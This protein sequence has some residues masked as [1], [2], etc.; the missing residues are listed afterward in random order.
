MTH[1]S[2]P[3]RSEEKLRFGKEERSVRVEGCNLSEIKS[4]VSLGEYPDF[5]GQDQAGKESPVCPV[6]G[7]RKNTDRPTPSVGHNEAAVACRYQPRF[8]R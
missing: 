4:L 1:S 5:P 2:K 6:S 3:P 7:E 8:R